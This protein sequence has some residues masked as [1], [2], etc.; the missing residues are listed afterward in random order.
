MYDFSKFK[1]K[2]KEVEGWLQKEFASVRT[3]RAAPALLDA[4]KVESYGSKVPLNQVANISVDDA[5]SI[6]VTPWDMSLSKDIEKAIM[7]ADLGVSLAVDDKGVRVN[8]PDLTG[9]R[10]EALVK[11]SKGKLEEAKVT[12]RGHRDGALKDIQAQEK[13]GGVGK[14]DVFRFKTELQKITDDTNKKLEEL[15]SKK[16]KEILN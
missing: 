1:A 4:V 14:D 5:R 12:L 8:F 15:Y 9:E 13:A 16:E 2:T 7:L 3:G 10:R 6:R 11:L